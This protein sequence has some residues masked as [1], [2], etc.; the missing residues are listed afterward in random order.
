[1][2]TT[3]SIR[4][5]EDDYEFVK[6]LAKEKK[7]EM[8]KAVRKLVD[9]GR[10]MYA[11]QDYKTGKISIGKAAELAG[12]SISE[13]MDVLAEYGIKSRID[14]NDYLRGLENLRKAW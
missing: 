4:M 8:S 9:L 5:H 11:I 14:Y 10:L 2:Q 12:I 1:M 3:L 7:E 6:K 13:M